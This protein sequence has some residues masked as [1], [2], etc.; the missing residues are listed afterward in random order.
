MSYANPLLIPNWDMRR[1]VQ[2]FLDSHP[3][4]VPDG[5]PDRIPP[6]PRDNH[7]LP[8]L[9]NS[10]SDGVGETTIPW[11]YVLCVALPSLSVFRSLVP[12]LLQILDVGKN[13][14]WR[15]N[16]VTL[17]LLGFL[18]G[19]LCLCGLVMLARR[20]RSLWGDAFILSLS[21]STGLAVLL[22]GALSCVSPELIANR[23]CL[24]A[25][26]GAILPYSIENA[27]RVT[28]FRNEHS[29]LRFLGL[30]SVAGLSYCAA[31]LRLGVWNSTPLAGLSNSS[32]G[33]AAL[34]FGV[35]FALCFDGWVDK[36]PAERCILALM[37]SSG[38]SLAVWAYLSEEWHLFPNC[39]L[40]A[41]GV[42]FSFASGMSLISELRTTQ[43]HWIGYSS[44]AMLSAGIAISI[45]G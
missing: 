26:L 19:F 32:A 37:L 3:G 30:L 4:F 13:D 23:C 31:L 18:F 41:G 7:P 17:K 28:G 27:N 42:I 11:P 24:G 34:L 16:A 20:H 12:D 2:R 35:F 8:R 43:I 1:R 39:L 40:I 5:W 36:G 33:A 21:R 44:F 10:T 14:I 9:S 25:I 45:H 38:I 22:I 29:V 6:L 15:K